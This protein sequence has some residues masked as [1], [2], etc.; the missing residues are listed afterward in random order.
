M[1]IIQFSTITNKC[2]FVFNN[3]PRKYLAALPEDVKQIIADAF[4]FMAART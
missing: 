1:Q 3:P 4:T 2:T